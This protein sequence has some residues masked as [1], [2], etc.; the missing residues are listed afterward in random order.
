MDPVFKNSSIALF[1]TILFCSLSFVPL[2]AQHQIFQAGASKID[3]TPTLGTKIYGNWVQPSATHIHDPLYA[4][5]LVLDDGNTKIALVIVDLVEANQRIYDLAK[6]YINTELGLKKEHILMAA[7]HTHSGPDARGDTYLTK[8]APLGE[9]P[10]LLARKLAD[11]VISAH[12]NLEPAQIAWGSVNV[13]DHLFVRRWIMKDSVFS[14]YGKREIVKMNPGFENPNL[15]KPSG[16]ID[17]AVSFISVQSTS[18]RPISVL[19]NY[20]LHYVGGVPEDEISAD[21]FGLFGNY[22]GQLMSVDEEFPRFVGIMSNG[23]SG[24]VNNLNFGKK[25]ENLAPY[26]KMNY[27]AKDVAVKV[28]ESLKK[29]NYKS[30]VPLAAE[31]SLMTLKTR[32]APPEAM[33]NIARIQTRSSTEKPFFSKWEKMYAQ[34]ILKMETEWPDEVDIQ[35]QAFRIGELGITALPFEAFTQTGLEIKEKSPFADTFTI[36]LANGCFNYLPTPEEIELGGY[37]T[38][39]SINRVEKYAS[40]KITKQLL[41]Q[42][43]NLK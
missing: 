13:P 9:Y 39:L 33:A 37:E 14:P 19:A 25:S 21:Y 2:R 34:R 42:L 16:P 31:Q 17:P 26:A 8:E 11:A 6:T 28:F 18:G 27:V 38:W 43:Q 1:F 12:N 23:T 40:E 4:K 24:N 30:W 41:K 15:L 20:A 35:L 36:E 22:L 5:A 7:T 29:A 3:I 32:R 10:S